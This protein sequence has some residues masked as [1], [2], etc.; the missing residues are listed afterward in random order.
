MLNPSSDSHTIEGIHDLPPNA[1]KLMQDAP[2]PD[3]QKKRSSLLGSESMSTLSPESLALYSSSPCTSPTSSGFSDD[4]PGSSSNSAITQSGWP[5]HLVHVDLKP[6][7]GDLPSNWMHQPWPG[8]QPAS[9]T[10]DLDESRPSDSPVNRQR[11]ITVLAPRL[12]WAFVPTVVFSPNSEYETF[13][14]VHDVNGNAF[15]K[16]VTKLERVSTVSGDMPMLYRTSLISNYWAT[17]ASKVSGL[18]CRA[19]VTS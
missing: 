19:F 12:V 18:Y 7:E 4:D 17:L 9:F 2:A 16:E 6:Y 10:L 5:R 3:L 11:R 14:A 1:S 15:Y 8:V 13:F